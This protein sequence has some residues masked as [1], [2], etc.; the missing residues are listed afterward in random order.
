[1][2]RGYKKKRNKDNNSQQKSNKP[3]PEVGTVNNNYIQNVIDRG[4]FRFE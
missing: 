1:M 2:G 3:R 4:N